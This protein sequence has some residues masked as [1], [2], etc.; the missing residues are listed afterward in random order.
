MKTRATLASNL[1][2][3]NMALEKEPIATQ[4]SHTLNKVLPK[5]E[6]ASTTKE[7]SLAKDLRNLVLK[8]KEKPYCS[9]KYGDPQFL[10]GKA[11]FEG[12]DDKIVCRHFAVYQQEEQASNPG[13][14][15]D[16]KKL[17]TTADISKNIRPNIEEKY[18]SL[19]LRA[20][21]A[22]LIENQEFGKFLVQQFNK[23]EE[24]GSLTRQMLI[25]STNHAMN[26]GLIIKQ[27]NQKKY[28]VVKLFET[29]PTNTGVRSKHENLASLEKQNLNDYFEY[30]FSL[31]AYYP[32]SIE[33]IG[34][35]AVFVR[36]SENEKTK[37]TSEFQFGDNKKL[38]TCV[39]YK[40][41]SPA[42][43]WHLAKNGFIGNLRELQEE[44]AKLPPKE[45]IALLD[46]KIHE[47][48]T[49][50]MVAA[51]HGRADVLEI[52]VAVGAN[53]NVQNEEGTSALMTAA[54]F[55]HVDAL[56]VIAPKANLDAQD[57]DGYTAA[58]MAA[59]KGH[60]EILKVL[61][62]N[63][64]NLDLQDARDYTAAMMAAEKGH[65]ETLKVLIEKGANLDLQNAQGYSAVM[66]AAQYG[67][68]ET[69]KVL[70]E[71]GA[72]LDLQNAQ[73][74]SAAMLVAQYGKVETLKVLSENGA[75]LDLQNAQ[76]YSA[77]MIAAQYGNVEIQKVLIEN[78]A[79]LDL[80]DAQGCT[81]ATIAAYYGNGEVLKV[82]IAA[83]KNENRTTSAMFAAQY[84]NMEILKVLLENGA[85]VNAINEYGDAAAMLAAQYGKV[86]IMKVLIENGANLD[87]QDAQGNTA[88]MIAAQYGKV[89]ILKVLIENGANLDLQDEQG[90]TAAMN[91][92]YYGHVDALKVIAPKANLDLQD[93]QGNTAMMFAAENG[94]VE[95]MKVLE[96]HQKK[97]ISP[98]TTGDLAK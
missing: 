26:I 34:L 11:F 39:P 24:D 84:G 55:D 78:G 48:Y 75:N 59:Q 97:S 3:M 50:A 90:Y 17:S 86:K 54:Y 14:K 74:Y 1:Q 52:L 21:E 53:L 9:S 31:P 83:E 68:V 38:T 41:L 36:P 19:K 44:I 76:G 67:K 63:G 12:T 89:E 65:V 51:Q 96:S 71:K 20:S 33:S 40:M 27:K 10:N 72:N 69:L 91:A 28:Y 80:Q 32:E 58:M 37:E 2:T 43:L 60:V 94:N 82:L 5:M 64:A 88:A 93:K 4:K 95:V 98:A 13:L 46:V 66:L 7:S 45:K 87:L 42:M 77:M 25:E 73:G 15:F 61:I 70:I 62:E 6:Q 22:H 35:S 23:M 30:K 92:A 8:N 56:K 49:A 85:D 18:R 57:T 47:G 81:A 29:N 79:N 16:F